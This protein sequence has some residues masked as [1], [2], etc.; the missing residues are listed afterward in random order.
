M[1]YRIVGGEAQRLAIGSFRSL[2]FTVRVQSVPEIVEDVRFVG[3]VVQRLGDESD[4]PGV[5]P[6]LVEGRSKKMEGVGVTWPLAEDL[7]EDG[8]RG[9]Q[10]AGSVSCNSCLEEWFWVGSAG[11]LG[12]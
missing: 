11:C 5:V 9:V 3:E 6:L 1:R 2:R 4:C 8:S 10:I 7:V 12:P